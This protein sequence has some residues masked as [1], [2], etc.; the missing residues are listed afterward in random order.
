MTC[1]CC[2]ILTRLSCALA[3]CRRAVMLLGSLSSRALKYWVEAA[4]M[5]Q[6]R[7]DIHGDY[8]STRDKIASPT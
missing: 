4:H 7:V 8:L 2:P 3:L 1:P 6:E 5:L